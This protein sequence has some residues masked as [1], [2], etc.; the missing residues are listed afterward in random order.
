M[1]KTI[2][3]LDPSFRHTGVAIIAHDIDGFAPR[4]I[5][6]K[7]IHT[8][9][10]AFDRKVVTEDDHQS[11]RFLYSEVIKLLNEWQPD[12]IL[13]ERPGGSQ[14]AAAAKLLGFVKMML[15]ALEYYYP[16]VAFVTPNQVKKVLPTSAPDKDDIIDWAFAQ[17]PEAPWRLRNGQ[18]MKLHEH[19]ADAIVVYHAALNA[20]L[21]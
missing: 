5:H 18:P 6:Q 11:A 2:L 13:A 1:D 7:T 20:G 9:K 21:L 16:H 10:G 3:C 12:M 17:H 19:E 15:V 4:V 8:K 14:S